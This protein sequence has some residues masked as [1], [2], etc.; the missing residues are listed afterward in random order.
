MKM[1][2]FNDVTVFR[3]TIGSWLCASLGIRGAA[4][5]ND[6]S[7]IKSGSVYIT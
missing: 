5:A 7:S 2:R 1:R 6:S 3:V 4:L